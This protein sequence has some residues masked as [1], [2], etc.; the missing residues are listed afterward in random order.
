[1]RTFLQLGALSAAGL[2]L[3]EETRAQEKQTTP[4]APRFLL[5]WGK[6]GKAEGEFDIP[7]GIAI[8]RHD[9]LFV[10]EFRNNRVQKFDTEGRLKAVYP[11]VEQPGGIAVDHAG[12]F[13]LAHLMPGKI[14]VY[15]PKGELLREWGKPGTG[16][17]EFQQPGGIAIARNGN[18]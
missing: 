16:D 6:R 14:T 12:N 3:P 15:S 8:S 11:V 17:G 13:Y 5:Q 9:E 2:L 1:R 4:P 7:I 18:L 10:T